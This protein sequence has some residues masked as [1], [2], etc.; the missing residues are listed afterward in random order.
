MHQIHYRLVYIALLALF[1][2]SLKCCYCQNETLAAGWGNAGVTWYGE[3]E[4]AGSTG[5]YHHLQ[6]H[7]YNLVLLIIGFK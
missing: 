2:V 6:Q 4:G 3:P 1:A 5:T 7:I